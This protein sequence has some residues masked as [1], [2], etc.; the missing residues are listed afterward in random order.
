MLSVIMPT[1]NSADTIERSLQSIAARTFA[2]HEVIVQDGSPDGDVEEFGQTQ[3]NMTIHLYRLRGQGVYDA[4]N[5][6]ERD[7]ARGSMRFPDDEQY[8]ANF[9]SH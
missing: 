5:K 2:D 4:M 1:F 8:C 6:K 3:G 9:I 7:I